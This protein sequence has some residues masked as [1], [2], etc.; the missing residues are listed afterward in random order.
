MI[1]EI[2]AGGN[3]CIRLDEDCLF[4]DSRHMPCADSYLD[5]FTIFGAAVAQLNQKVILISHIFQNSERSTNLKHRF[6]FFFQKHKLQRHVYP[7][8]RSFDVNKRAEWEESQGFC[9]TL[10]KSILY[11]SEATFL[12]FVD[13][14]LF[15]FLT[16]TKGFMHEYTSYVSSKIKF[17]K[18]VYVDVHLIIICTE[19]NEKSKLVLQ[20]LG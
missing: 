16:G 1:Y 14:A 4:C 5:P 10:H 17:S 12:N 18:S 11:K 13:I 9:K 20:N 7:W 15:D 2:L 19:K 3:W 8:R 6:A